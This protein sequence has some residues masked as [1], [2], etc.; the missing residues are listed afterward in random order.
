MSSRYD[1]T[2]WRGVPRIDIYKLEIS[3]PWTV[4][5]SYDGCPWRP[6]A[7]VDDLYHKFQA[8]LP[9]MGAHGY[10]GIHGIVGYR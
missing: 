8:M 4:I 9:S 2:Q 3:Y 5:G 1:L 10:V 7:P 6:F